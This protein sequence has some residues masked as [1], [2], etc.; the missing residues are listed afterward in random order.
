MGERIA[1][2][3]GV[4]GTFPTPIAV[5]RRQARAGPGAEPVKPPLPGMESNGVFTLR[6]IPDT[7]RIK[8]YIGQNSPRRAVIVMA[9]Q[10]RKL[11]GGV[12]TYLDKAG[13]SRVNLFV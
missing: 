9:E 2:I 7:D 8:Q 13:E 5:C 12:A 1:I 3:G 10:V 4:A 6:S 11:I